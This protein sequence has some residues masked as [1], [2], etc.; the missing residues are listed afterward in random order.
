MYLFGWQLLL[1]NIYI[2]RCVT[3][4][5]IFFF[6]IKSIGLIIEC[7]IVLNTI[8]ASG[9]ITESIKVK[10]GCCYF[11]GMSKGQVIHKGIIFAAPIRLSFI[12]DMLYLAKNLCR[13]QIIFKQHGKNLRKRQICSIPFT[14]IKS[15]NNIFTL[16][17]V[18][19]YILV[20]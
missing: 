8:E 11:Q 9:L 1:A 14:S 19:R 15:Q 5:F 7:F 6:S 2:I 20:V 13:L 10:G 4:F 12:S 16:L 17:I 18:I 3:K